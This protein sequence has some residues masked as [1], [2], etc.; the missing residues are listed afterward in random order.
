MK[1]LITLANLTF[2][3][4]NCNCGLKPKITTKKLLKLKKKTKSNIKHI[5]LY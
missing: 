4:K 2:T 3:K 5:K 1:K